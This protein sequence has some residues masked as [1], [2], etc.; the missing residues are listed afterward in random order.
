MKLCLI[1]GD[2]LSPNLSSLADHH[3]QTDVVL[4]CEVRSEATYVKHHKKKIAFVFSAMRHFAKGL[5]DDGYDVR[6]VQYDDQNNTGSLIGEVGR[7]ITQEPITEIVVTAPAEH[8]LQTE[9]TGWSLE[10]NLPVTIKEDDRFLCSPDEFSSWAE[11]RKQLRMEYFYREMRRKYS[12][13]MDQDGPIGGQWNYD[14]ENRKPPSSGLVVPDTFCAQHDEITQEVLALVEHH[15]PDHFG[16]LLPFHFAISR[17]QALAALDQFIAKRLRL[18]GDY[19]DAMVQNEPWMYHSHIGFYLNCGLLNPLECIERAE[20]AYHKGVAP[21]NAVEG[22]IRQ[23]LG[24]REYLRGIYWLKMPDY[25]SG[26]FL[27]ARRQLPDFY[28]TADTQM[29]CMRQCI[30]ETKQNAYAHHIQRLMV[31]GNFA[32]LAGIAPDEVNNWY[33]LVYADAYEWVELPNVTG[34]VLF[35]DGGLLASK[36]YAASGAYINKMS[37]YCGSCKYKVSVKNGPNA[38]PFN[39]LYWDFIGRNDDKLRGN[40]RMGFM[41]KSLDRMSDEK[42]DA[43]QEDSR[44]FLNAMDAD[45]K[46]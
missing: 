35:A 16:D 43:I 14:A 46:I 5:S 31:L 3:T 44:R 39:Y 9:M 34:M 17:D 19:Q 20:A 22:F 36:P 25:K 41:Y 26:N 21:L 28:W 33:L 29:N 24:W 23:V 38:C 6:Y 30:T 42:R 8:R 10:L 12:I 40:P 2:Q 11:G 15:F 18:F 4:M 37:N 1:L 7:I 45:E 27:E 13:L 32:L